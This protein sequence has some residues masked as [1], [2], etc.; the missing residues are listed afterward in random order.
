MRPQ[1]NTSSQER[2]QTFTFACQGATCEATLIQAGNNGTVTLSGE[3]YVG[4]GR[5]YEIVANIETPSGVTVR[6]CSWSDT[7]D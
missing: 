1:K 3:S 5:Y 4:R 2:K 6:S 7:F